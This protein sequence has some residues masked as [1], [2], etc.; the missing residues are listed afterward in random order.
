MGT[1]KKL[2]FI[3][4][5]LIAVSIL[6][7]IYSNFP[8]SDVIKVLSSANIEIVILSATLPFV[9]Y[10]TASYRLWQLVLN[11]GVKMTFL[12]IFEINLATI[13]Y[14]LFLPGG[15]MAGGV[16]RVYKI[17]AQDRRV[18]E[19]L[20]SITFDRVLATLALFIV[21]ILFWM[22]N[23]PSKSAYLVSVMIVGAI[24]IVLLQIAVWSKYIPVLTNSIYLNNKSYIASKIKGMLRTISNYRGLS[25]QNYIILLVISIISQFIGILSYYLLAKSIG[26]EVSFTAMGWVRS[27]VILVTMIP[28]SISGFGLREGALLYLL[29]SYAVAADKTL[30]LSLLVYFITIFTIGVIG[31]LIE[32]V[33]VFIFKGNE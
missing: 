28:V 8:L 24:L 21:G 6:F 4:R 5:L 9:S 2:F 11:Q 30:A 25:F 32:G 1:H 33:R 12:K 16:V 18:V 10:L 22:I 19:T 15:N 29:H 26:I 20:A 17:S 3:I 31:G 27:A 14:G 7:F 23:K 13:F